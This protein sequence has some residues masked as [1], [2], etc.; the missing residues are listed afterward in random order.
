MSLKNFSR[1]RGE[2]LASVT[3]LKYM[4]MQV[5]FCPYTSKNQ[6]EALKKTV[7][8]KKKKMCFPVD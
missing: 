6:V 1:V 3:E 5:Y 7:K 8:K 4:H 2:P